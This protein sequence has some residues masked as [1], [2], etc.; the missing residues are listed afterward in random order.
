M[1]KS[2]KPYDELRQYVNGLSGQPPETIEEGDEETKKWIE[3]RQAK[4]LTIHRR[5][6]EEK[7]EWGF[8][9]DEEET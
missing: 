8:Y 3:K 1:G 9:K 6:N 2:K 4:P 5:Y 7:D